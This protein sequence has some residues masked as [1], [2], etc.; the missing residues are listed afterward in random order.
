MAIKSLTSV[1]LHEQDN[2]IVIKEYR[3]FYHEAG[4]RSV[5][6]LRTMSNRPKG[7]PRLSNKLR[8]GQ[9]VP[10]YIIHRVMKA[11]C[12]PCEIDEEAMAY[13]AGATDEYIG[14]IFELVDDYINLNLVDKPPKTLNI[15]LLDK[16]L[17]M[18]QDELWM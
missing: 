7:S 9:N 14:R 15:D 10:L 11:E 8:T 17:A 13:F 5:H 1:S 4:E 3:K 18:Q 12:D 2:D 6:R 16:A